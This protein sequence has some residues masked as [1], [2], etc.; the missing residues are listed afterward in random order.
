MIYTGLSEFMPSNKMEYFGTDTRDPRLLKIPG[1]S[2]EAATFLV[3]EREVVG[4]GLDAPSADSSNVYDEQ[5][6][7]SPFAHEIFNGANVYIIENINSN[8]KKLIN[9]TNIRV[10]SL[11]LPIETASG[12]P[13]RLIAQKVTDL[14]SSRSA[15]SGA[16]VSFAN[17]QWTFMI[18]FIVTTLVMA[19]HKC[20]L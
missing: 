19:L 13:I 1:F 6:N 12:S 16:P 11:P 14:P 3:E 17:M 5:S 10:S 7:M 4:V 2:K 18:M 8:L 15:S 9:E 20:Q